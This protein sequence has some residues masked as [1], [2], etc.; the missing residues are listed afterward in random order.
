MRVFWLALALAAA[1]LVL[2]AWTS[3]AAT[4]RPTCTAA[5]KTLPHLALR[6]GYSLA[7]GP[8]FA[9]VRV[10]GATYR[11]KGSK[12]FR[13]KT[14]ARLYF[15]AFDFTN[16]AQSL[17]VQNSLYLVVERRQAQPAVADMIDGGMG[18]VIRTRMV[19]SGIPA[20][21]A[22]LDGGLKRGTF[23]GVGRSTG[24]LEGVR[25]TGSWNCG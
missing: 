16:P 10:K 2:G 1:V 24:N 20:G 21:V 25:F 11:I 19:L 7:C 6:D 12:C 17:P 22:H 4:V 18:L 9:V 15:G 5:D 23:A 8:G 14:G 3:T 13:G